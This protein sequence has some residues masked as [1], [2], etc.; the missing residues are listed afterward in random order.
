MCIVTCKCYAILY[1]RLEHPWIWVSTGVLEP[2][3]LGHYRTLAL[4]LQ[5]LKLD[6]IKKKPQILKNKKF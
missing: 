2:I 5:L 4:L 3:P 6:T 1:K